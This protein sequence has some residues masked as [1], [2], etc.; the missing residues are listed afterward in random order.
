ME[1]T[2]LELVAE[3]KADLE[4]VQQFLSNGTLADIGSAH[5]YLADMKETL[6]QAINQVG[7]L[8]YEKV[9]ELRGK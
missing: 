9:K 7:N 8:H 3:M 5:H 4:S 2:L 6:D 1:K